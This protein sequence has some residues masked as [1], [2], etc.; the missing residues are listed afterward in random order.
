MKP[1]RLTAQFTSQQHF[2]LAPGWLKTLT[3]QPG[4]RYRFLTIP[5][6]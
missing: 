5:E 1:P 4:A 2:A 3:F 6:V